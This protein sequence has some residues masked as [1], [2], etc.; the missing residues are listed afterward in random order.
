ML[1]IYSKAK[2]KGDTMQS[3]KFYKNYLFSNIFL[4][5]AIFG[6]VTAIV[7][8]QFSIRE[9][10]SEI[11]TA[12]QLLTSQ[13]T[14]LDECIIDSETTLYNITLQPTVGEIC[15]LQ[16]P[17]STAD[18]SLIREFALDLN[19]YYSSQT[20]FSN[21]MLFLK[22][23]E[24]FLDVGTAG[25]DPTIFYNSRFSNS[26]LSY[27]NWYQQVSSIDDVSID[28]IYLANETTETF[29]LYN[30][31]YS[32]FGNEILFIETF[33]SNPYL[34]VLQTSPLFSESEL[35]V[36][37]FT[38]QSLLYSSTDAV[39][40]ADTLYSLSSTAN[41]ESITLNSNSYTVITDTQQSMCVQYI[42]LLSNKTFF[43]A[44]Q[45]TIFLLVCIM[46][47]L[48][49]AFLLMAI[50]I[51]YQTSQPIY[52]LLKKT[53]GIDTTSS[54]NAKN[55]LEYIAAAFDRID[56][57][58]QTL[59]TQMSA[60]YELSKN[61]F[62]TKLLNG[63][64]MKQA[65]LVS[66][67]KHLGGFFSH[68]QYSLIAIDLMPTDL[69][70]DE[71]VKM[72][73]RNILTQ[74]TTED[75]FVVQTENSRFCIILS[76]ATESEDHLKA[77]TQEI[78]DY[79]T[80]HLQQ[81]ITCVV[82]D[83]CQLPEQLTQEYQICCYVFDTLLADGLSFQNQI[84]FAHDIKINRKN[85]YY[86]LFEEQSLLNCINSKKYEQA[87]LLLNKLF[88]QNFIELSLPQ[89]EHA[90][91]L[92]HICSTFLRMIRTEE[93]SNPEIA[94]YVDHAIYQIK[95]SQQGDISC[96]KLKSVIHVLENNNNTTKGNRG[97]SIFEEIDDRIR[98]HFSNPQ[99]SITQLSLDMNLSENYLSVTYR[100]YTNH[101]IAATIEKVRMEHAAMLL[102]ES[103]K[104]IK[105]VCDEAGYTNL[106]TFYKAFKRYYGVTPSDYRSIQLPE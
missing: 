74:F 36:I 44:T 9:K 56:L 105:D 13:C 79:V 104:Y 64:S 90:L 95:Q 96:E 57:R 11:A 48:L 28:T 2:E 46:T 15:R 58:N 8:P 88:E 92:D 86:P 73:L 4:T 43:Q 70:E 62:F 72:M 26:E 25:V 17:Y 77:L 53:H 12:Q 61:I 82:S 89:K 23:S 63:V 69:T 10:N 99:F 91:F 54:D 19:L 52:S 101:S 100:Q 21:T 40:D 102:K 51:A 81:D 87:C 16:A 41:G 94:A 45:N 68:S 18:F 3:K 50:Y 59:E 35:I 78:T 32:L 27:E 67:S 24:L 30:G 80:Q 14:W 29:V 49:L 55:E 20:T 83:I 39:L 85:Y 5:V 97:Y 106:N 60:H 93:P 37:D 31:R 42:W 65:E 22:N 33:E 47:V 75:S 98:T 1:Y 84:V 103:E 7:L 6:C 66:I 71:I 34:E 76:I 38:T